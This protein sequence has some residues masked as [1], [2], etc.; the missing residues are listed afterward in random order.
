[1]YLECYGYNDGDNEW[2]SNTSQWYSAGQ[3]N[4]YFN[5]K[6]RSQAIDWGAVRNEGRNGLTVTCRNTKSR[7]GWAEVTGTIHPD[8]FEF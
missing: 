7:N 5:R 1:M 3:K 4:Q 6:G 2:E 8:K